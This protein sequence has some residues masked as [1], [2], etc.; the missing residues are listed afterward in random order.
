MSDLVERL[1][2]ALDLSEAGIV[3]QRQ[4][5][6]RRFPDKSDREIDQLLNRWLSERPGA[7]HGDGPQPTTRA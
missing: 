6:R 7:E 2:T 5:L 4:T 1:R 3:L